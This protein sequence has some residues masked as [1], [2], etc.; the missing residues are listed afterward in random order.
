MSLPDKDISPSDVQRPV[1]SNKASEAIHYKEL[2]ET[3]KRKENTGELEA[4]VRRRTRR[5]KQTPLIN[6]QNNGKLL[7]VENNSLKPSSPLA[8]VPSW[9]M[10][11]D[12]FA[13]ALFCVELD[14]DVFR[15]Q[16]VEGFPSNP[17]PSEEQ[18]ANLSIEKQP[19]PL[20]SFPG[21]VRGTQL[22]YL[23]TDARDPFGLAMANKISMDWPICP[24]ELLQGVCQRPFCRFQHKRDYHLTLMEQCRHAQTVGQSDREQWS[25]NPD[26]SFLHWPIPSQIKK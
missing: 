23:A 6:G 12:A 19:S 15:N 5:R 11:L 13:E 26:A 17:S 22:M 7:D 10:S 25:G 14:L 18:K 24:Q 3:T 2:N 20:K 16:F 9:K 4:S 1:E 8:E 21:L